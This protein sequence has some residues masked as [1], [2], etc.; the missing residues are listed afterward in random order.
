MAVFTPN[1]T[2]TTVVAAVAI[3]TGAAP[4]TRGT[5][6]LTASY[7]AWLFVRVGS[8]GVTN[9]DVPV[10]IQIRPMLGAKRHPSSVTTRTGIV[11]AATASTTVSTDAAV[12]ATSIIVA[13]GTGVVAGDTVMITDAA[14]ARLE[15]ARVSKV[16]GTT[17]YLDA[18]LQF[19]HTAAQADPV[20]NAAQVFAKIRLDGGAIWEIIFDLG[21]ATS[22]SNIVV[23]AIAVNYVS[24]TST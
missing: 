21:A 19:A 2:E 11:N 20:T 7:G 4:T 24:D 22:G 13:S 16:S 1:Y 14:F 12:A 6:D 17:L 9:L 5:I 18:P 3:S 23:Q 15:F 10:T 8:T